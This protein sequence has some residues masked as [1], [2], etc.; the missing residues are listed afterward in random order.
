[1]RIT[2][3]QLRQIIKEELTR[4]LL[5]GKEDSIGDTLSSFYTDLVDTVL[6][7]KQFNPEAE[8]YNYRIFIAKHEDGGTYAIIGGL[9]EIGRGFVSPVVSS[10]GP[11]SPG[12]IKYGE[13]S[14]DESSARDIMAAFNKVGS[15]HGV[16]TVSATNTG[17]Y[18]D[19]E[20][21]V[22][23]LKK[24]AA[25]EFGSETELSDENLLDFWAVRL[26]Y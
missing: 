14:G 3:R 16:S 5:E 20:Y 25:G 18:K 24:N 22:M 6:T 15:R 12:P 1:M 13:P 17:S 21:K 19:S 4:S 9:N 23:S 2:G 11:I 26:N 7:R 8:S 10:K